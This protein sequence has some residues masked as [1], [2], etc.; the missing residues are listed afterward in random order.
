[1]IKLIKFLIIIC[2]LAL[3]GIYAKANNVGDMVGYHQNYSVQSF[4]LP[5][6]VLNGIYYQIQSEEDMT[7]SV[8][9]PDRKSVV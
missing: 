8:C 3:V 1:M 5:S 2:L 6:F 4:F 7:A 9:E